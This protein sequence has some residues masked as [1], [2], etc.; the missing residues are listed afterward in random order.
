MEI[1]ECG[2]AALGMVLGYYGRIVPLAQLRRECRVSRDGSKA[3]NVLA[4]ARLHG[5]VGKGFKKEVEGLSAFRYPYI[6]FWNFNHFLVVEGCRGGRV[7][8]N[9]PASGPRSVTLEEFDEA[10]TGVVLVME[11]G[12]TFEKG[13]RRPTV[14]AGLW[15]RLHGSIRPLAACALAALFLVVPGLAAPALTQIFVDKV[16]I[17]GTRDWARPLILGI[18]L[19]GLLRG[20]LSGLQFRLLRQLKTKLSVVMSSRFVWHLLQLPAGYYA[21]RFSGEI[22]GRVTLNDKVAD[23]LSGPLAT[24][25]IDIFM[26]LFYAVVMFQFDS[27]LTAIALTFAVLNFL[28]LRWVSRRRV[29]GNQKLTME[30]GKLNGIA[31]SGLQSI[32]TLKASALESDFFSRW[33][34]QFAKASNA[35]QELAVADQYLGALPR[36]LSALMTVLILTVGGLRVMDGAMSIGMLVAFQSLTASFLAPVNSVLNL[37]GTLQELVG[38]LSRLDDVLR[39]PT[40][41]DQHPPYDAGTAQSFSAQLRGDVEFKNVTFAYSGMPPPLI[42]GLSFSVRPGQR[43]ALVGDSGSGKSTVAKLVCGLYEPQSGEI[44]FD[45]LPRQGIPREI[46][47]NSISSVDQDILLFGGSVRDNLTLWDNTVTDRQLVKACED[48]LIHDVVAALPDG[49]RSEL[50]E[51]AANLSGGQRQRLEIARAL[52]NEPSILILDEATSALDAETEKRIDQSIRLRGCTCIIVAHRLS[53][54]RDCD[55]IIVLDRGKVVQ[56][57]T[58]DGLIREQGPYRTLISTDGGALQEAS[59]AD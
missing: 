40:Q 41:T 4:A 3:S 20:L 59:S 57:G 52:I 55:E 35:Q 47:T 15:D 1:A 21:Q 27:V 5:L 42:E 53:T 49:Y 13:G 56:R 37:G 39:N 51:G 29:D 18:L 32:R 17:E 7:Y 30:F 26:M 12:P 8:L 14:A 38:E 10:F 11:P 31:I 58:H 23:V 19:A 34:G 44:L 45:G 50:L 43:L 36:F 54:I 22:A 9:D 24:T 28:V 2:A 25:V 46:L 6:V 16:L 48:A 33:T